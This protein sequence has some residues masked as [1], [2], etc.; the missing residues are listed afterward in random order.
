[1]KLKGIKIVY[2]ENGEQKDAEFIAKFKCGYQSNR[3]IKSI[4]IDN[5]LTKKLNG[6]ETFIYIDAPDFIYEEI[7]LAANEIINRSVNS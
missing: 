2:E 7:M 3:G 5:V 1:M 4:E 6:I